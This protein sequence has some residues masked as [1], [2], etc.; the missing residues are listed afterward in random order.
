[1][2]VWMTDAAVAVAAGSGTQH[3]RPWMREV[4]T[5]ACGVNAAQRGRRL[6]MI[7]DTG[8]MRHVR[9][10]LPLLAVATERRHPRM[11]VAVGMATRLPLH[12]HLHMGGEADT[13]TRPMDT[14]SHHE[15]HP[16]TLM[17]HVLPQATVTRLVQLQATEKLRVSR[18][19]TVMPLALHLHTGRLPLAGG[20]AV[21]T[22]T[23]PLPPHTTGSHTIAGDESRTVRFFS[24]FTVSVAHA[25]C[26]Q[27]QLK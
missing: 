2:G 6:A 10:R 26:S 8:R 27:R 14:V 13:T 23:K 7:Q 9:L 17:P 15:H 18:R 3:Q 16:P 4:D 5:V 25:S 19:G 21:G 12:P 20:M 24:V 22:T 1:M 11:V